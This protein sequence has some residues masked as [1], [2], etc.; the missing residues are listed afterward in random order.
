MSLLHNLE[1]QELSLSI[2]ID[3]GARISSLSYRGYE[4][5]LPFRGQILTWGWYPMAPWAGRIKNGIIRDKSGLNIQLPTN[6]TPP[7]AIHGQ[8]LFDSWQ[9]LGQGYFAIDF[10][11]PYQGA[12]LEQRFEIL[13]NALRWSLEYEGGDCDLDFWLGMHPWFP[14]QL[15][16]GQEA[17]IEFTPTFMFERGQDYLPTGKMILP[18]EG[19]WDDTFIG[20]K[21]SPRIYWQDAMQIT[22]DSDC[23]Y[24]V[25][26]DQ[27]P[28]GICIEPQSA[29]PDA[30]NLGI[31]SENYLEALFIFDEI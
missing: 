25:I 9:E 23:P 21:G 18:T 4:S 8:T 31:T 16:S 6:L 26:Y 20:V 7:H 10:T 24:W 12:R 28:E 13:D 22:I 19:P 11:G 2:D 27:D 17:E 1:G 3:Q 30:Q 14:R 5:V 29:P 15:S